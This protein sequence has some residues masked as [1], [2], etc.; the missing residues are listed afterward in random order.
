MAQRYKIERFQSNKSMMYLP[1]SFEFDQTINMA[2]FGSAQKE[3]VFLSQPNGRNV[4]SISSTLAEG[5][6]LP[7]HIETIH[8]FIKNGC[9]HLGP[10]VGIFSS[11]FTPFQ[12]RPIGDRSF[13]FSKILSSQTAAGVVPFLFGEGHIDWEH[14]LI[15]GYFFSGKGWETAQVP[16]PNVVYDRLPNRRS[17]KT[18]H[19]RGVK[20]KLE[21]EYLIPWYNPGFFNKLEIFEKLYN[22]PEVEQYLPETESFHSFHQLEKMLSD[23]GQVFVKPQ[24]GSLGLGVHQI[25][26]DKK[27]NVYYCRYRDQE[28]RLQ[29][30]QTIESLA[31]KVF[32]KR[33]LERMLVQ[34]G[35]YLIKHEQR[36]IDFRVHVNKDERG[37]WV[38][39]A[40][41]AKI[42]G[43]GSP[44]THLNNG[45]E[46]KTLEEI[47][48]D[49]QDQVV[50]KEALER[51]AILLAH[52][53]EKQMTGIIGEIGF[54]FGIDPSGKVWL[55]EANSKPGRSIFSHPGLKAVDLL[56]RK[57]ALSFAVFLTEQ[58]F[59]NPEELFR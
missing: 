6:H 50:N 16:L 51:A 15:E 20:E 58:T 39:S 29:K 37:E 27:E 38:V 49:Q 10:L 47:F 55:F 12:I 22:V 17:E 7:H 24:N 5:L 45:G 8:V 31:K 14:G 34:Q 35:I 30:F 21:R 59:E 54:D 52:A 1:L 42:A 33:P 9:L 25:I 26:Y 28:N 53:L 32:A 48:P 13:L 43:S 46:V 56:T 36:P 18:K 2:G 40:I 11:G 57:L 41:A 19:S 4:I 3:A 23:Y 44:T